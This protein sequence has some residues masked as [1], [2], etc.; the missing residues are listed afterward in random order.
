MNTQTSSMRTTHTADVAS[1]TAVTLAKLP[2]LGQ[3]IDHCS[4]HDAL[5]HIAAC[6]AAGGSHQ[7]ATLNLD[8]LRLSVQQPELGAILRRCRH[9][10]ADGWPICQLARWMDQTGQ[11][12]T[13]PLQRVTGSDLTP[14][15]FAAAQQRG[16]RIALVGGHDHMVQPL[17][18]QLK[19]RYGI[20]AVGHWTPHYDVSGDN[21]SSVA[22]RD[23]ALAREIRQQ[24]PDIILVALGCPKQEYWLAENLAVTGA[25]VGI[26]IGASLDFLV[27]T[28][29]RAPRV[30]QALR[31][32]FVFRLL[33][34]PRRLFKRYGLD[35]IFYAAIVLLLKSTSFNPSILSHGYL[36]RQVV[37]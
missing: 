19:D 11:T 36:D 22:M 2:V 14:L 6:I 24:Q 16:W 12:T 37:R 35:A 29:V 21:L 7:V 10:Y 31:A 27:G 18:Q 26:G 17:A 30:V 23:T 1:A 20:E 28:Q 9:C 25:A 34:Q 15:I 8:M 32:E 5:D 4:L 3:L 33:C 13:H